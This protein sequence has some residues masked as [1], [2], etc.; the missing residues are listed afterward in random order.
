MRV[1]VNIN[2]TDYKYNVTDENFGKN[3]WLKSVDCE[4]CTCKDNE[5]NIEKEDYNE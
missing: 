4:W 5:S 3:E 1:I 2:S